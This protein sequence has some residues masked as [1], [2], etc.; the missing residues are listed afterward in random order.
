[1]SIAYLSR[2]AEYSSCPAVSRISR[3]QGTS[4]TVTCLRYITVSSEHTN[5][6][7]RNP[8]LLGHRFLKRITEQRKKIK[9]T[10]K[11]ILHKP[12]SQC[13]LAHSTTSYY[14]NLVIVSVINLLLSSLFAYHRLRMPL[15]SRLPQFN[16]I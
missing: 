8:R 7:H 9:D 13:A 14:N 10:H 5:Y 15:W 2:I 3:T 11:V 6:K 16:N 4:S 12:N 1:M